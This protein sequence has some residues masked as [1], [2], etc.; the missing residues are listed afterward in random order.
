MKNFFYLLL[1][2]FGLSSC[3]EHYETRIVFEN[4]TEYNVNVKLNPSPSAEGVK[5]EFNLDAINQ[6]EV[7]YHID[8]SDYDPSKLLSDGYSSFVIEIDNPNKDRVVFAKNTEPDYEFNPYTDLDSW[9]YKEFNYTY[10]Y[11]FSSDETLIQEYT[12]IIS[13]DL[14]VK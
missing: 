13:D 3:K 14:V 12:F 9:E 11:N 2:F 7:I 1:L 8:V 10:K 6:D 4:R 5:F